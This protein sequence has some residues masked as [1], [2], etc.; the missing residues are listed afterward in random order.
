MEIFA[1]AMLGIRNPKAHKNL[2]IS[3]ERAIH[4]PFL[5]GLLFFKSDERL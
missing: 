1:G 5:A 2:T 3:R 4:H